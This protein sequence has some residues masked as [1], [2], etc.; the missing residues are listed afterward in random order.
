MVQQYRYGKKQNYAPKIKKIFISFS[1]HTPVVGC[2]FN[3][4]HIFTDILSIL[5]VKRH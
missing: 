5:P 2:L 3:F 1:H 4:P